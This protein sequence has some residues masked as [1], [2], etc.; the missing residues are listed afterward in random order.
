[1][2]AQSDRQVA[3]EMTMRWKVGLVATRESGR[4]RRWLWWDAASSK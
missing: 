1:M 3:I 2:G 4:S